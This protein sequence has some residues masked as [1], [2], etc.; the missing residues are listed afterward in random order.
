LNE[1]RFIGNLGDEPS[2]RFTQ[3]QQAVMNFRIGCT[4][5]Y[6]D[7]NSKEWKERTEWVTV[8]VWGKRAEALNKLLRKGSRVFVAGRFQT[9]SW[10]KNGEK[11]YAT[12]I[13]ANNIILLGGKGEHQGAAAGGGEH[14]D[15][16][17][18]AGG[19]SGGDTANDD[20]IPF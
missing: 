8:V 20:N 18:A 16:F 2:L 13:V 4:E 15:D 19:F 3:S 6:L 5:R 17:Q 14:R 10:E 12:E 7:S 11:R 1:C 9:R